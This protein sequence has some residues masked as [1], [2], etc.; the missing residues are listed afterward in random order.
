MSLPGGG[1]M[2]MSPAGQN[3]LLKSMIEDLCGYFTPGGDVVYVGDSN[4]KWA[5]LDGE[6]LAGLGGR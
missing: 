6:A 3:L 5:V 2:A 1:L 4:A